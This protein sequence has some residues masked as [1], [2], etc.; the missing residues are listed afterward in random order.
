MARSMYSSDNSSKTVKSH[1]Y[2]LGSWECDWLMRSALSPTGPKKRHFLN[3]D[4][5]VPAEGI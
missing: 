5:C 3:E 1:T 2:K 4:G